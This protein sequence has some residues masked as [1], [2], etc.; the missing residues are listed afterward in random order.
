MINISTTDFVHFSTGLDIPVRRL[1]D[2]PSAV[3]K[4][5]FRYVSGD[6]HLS[7][8]QITRIGVAFDELPA[9]LMGDA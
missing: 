3:L 7:H 9:P 2:F 6:S 8:F 5:S 4:W 1:V